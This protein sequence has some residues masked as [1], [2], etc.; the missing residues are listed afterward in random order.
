[1]WYRRAVFYAMLGAVIVLPAWLLVSRGIIFTDTG[2]DFLGYLVLAPL[3][4]VALG[5]VA[6]VVWA[7]KSVRATRAVSPLDAALL[8]AW[9]LSIALYGASGDEGVATAVAVV[10]VLLAVA[11]FWAAVWQLVRETRSRL[12]NIVTTFEQQAM[13]RDGQGP[14]QNAGSGPVIRIEPPTDRRP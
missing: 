2:W 13:P 10:G 3:L 4:A 5:I 9:Y 14:G 8:T 7:R 1:M 12:R 11:S 6:A